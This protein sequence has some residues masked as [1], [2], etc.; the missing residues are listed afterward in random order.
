MRVTFTRATA[1]LLAALVLT[2][3]VTRLVLDP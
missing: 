1:L 2:A 3:A